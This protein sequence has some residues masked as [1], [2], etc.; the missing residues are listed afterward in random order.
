MP[1]GVG[2][3]SV[4]SVTS[5]GSEGVCTEDKVA[6]HYTDGSACPGWC[7]DSADGTAWLQVNGCLLMDNYLIKFFLLIFI[8]S[9]VSA[10]VVTKGFIK[11]MYRCSSKIY[12]VN[13]FLCVFSNS[14]YTIPF[15]YT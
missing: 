14:K 2:N 11:N 4:V 15:M 1:L 12:Y 7:A 3:V 5:S 13:I 6:L 8:F 10:M 9:N